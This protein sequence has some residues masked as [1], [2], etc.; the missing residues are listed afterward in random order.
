MTPSPPDEVIHFRG[1][2]LTP[3]SPR[4][5]HPP[6]PANIPLL[7]NQMDPA[8]DDTAAY[9]NPQSGE[10]NAQSDDS[11]PA[12]GSFPGLVN[13]RD[14][15]GGSGQEPGSFHSGSQQVDG[16]MIRNETLLS[17]AK[18]AFPSDLSSPAVTE[19]SVARDA[20]APSL[21]ALASDPAALLDKALSENPSQQQPQQAPPV[22]PDAATTALPLNAPTA[23]EVDPAAPPS[24]KEQPA[25]H[26]AHDDDNDGLDTERRG[27][28]A[29]SGGE[30]GVDFQNL[31]DHLSPSASTA[32]SGPAV[33]TTT[34]T[35]SPADESA[36]PPATTDRSLPTHT[37]LPPRPPPQEK[38]AIHPNYTPSDDIRSY[39]QFPQQSN[40][41]YASQQSNYPPS[42]G[43]PP[44]V[45]A[46]G[47]PGTAS[48]ANGLPPPPVASFQQPQPSA[49]K[50]QEAS[51]QPSQ[52]NNKS[53]RHSGRP[54]E[55]TP[56]GPDVQKKYDEF[57][58]DERVYVTEGNWDRFP[59]G[60]RLFVGQYTPRFL[61]FS[62]PFFFCSP[63]PPPPLSPLSFFL[64]NVHL[65]NLPTER[66]TKRDLF[67]V[68]HKYGKLAQIS[69]KQAYGFVQF[70]DANACYQALQGE[71]GGVVRGRKIRKF[72]VARCFY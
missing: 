65:G 15:A 4:P 6:E 52:K 37:G 13:G 64:S 67:H 47:A 12:Y 5:L 23:S 49:G 10:D 35:T 39:H 28:A 25:S 60:S 18:N 46:P 59:P 54:D 34:T 66:V 70:L 32:P 45:S 2:T 17:S 53:D 31:L 58:Q 29:S 72:Y 26:D 40:P 48:G 7:Q 63:P 57:L 22:A 51:T 8:F 27:D 62:L 19:S 3:E 43:L 14:A 36:P 69:I 56:W 33:T 9:E 68:F 20:A 21:T 11:I 24:S 44:L 55:D 41:S 61:F 1:K 38:P 50:P 30:D 16:S 42:S 71:Q